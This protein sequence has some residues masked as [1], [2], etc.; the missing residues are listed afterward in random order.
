MLEY[1]TGVLSP[2]TAH[3]YRPHHVEN[4]VSLFGEHNIRLVYLPPNCTGELQ[5]L[6]LSGNADFKSVLKAQFVEW[7]ADKVA[8]SLTAGQDPSQLKVNL[9]LSTLKPVHAKWVMTAW[10]SLY[11]KPDAILN[12]WKKA[13]IA[14]ALDVTDEAI[15]I[16]V[17]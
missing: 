17:D 6:D 16:I 2:L 15:N 4:V 7:Y 12:G 5:P 13:G 8:S 1:I 14:S 11:E 3:V 10:E 9:R